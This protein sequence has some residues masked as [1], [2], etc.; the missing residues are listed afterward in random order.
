MTK[1]RRRSDQ[2]QMLVERT[3]GPSTALRSVEKHFQERSAEL[4]IPQLPGFPV[5][6]WCDQRTSCGFPQRK[7]HTW[8]SLVLRSRKSGVRSPGFPVEVGG[9]L[10]LHA[11]FLT[12][13]R[14]R[15]RVRRC[16]TG[17]PGRDDK[18]RVVACVRIRCWWR[19]LQI[20]PLRFAPVGMTKG[21]AALRSESD[22]GKEN[23]RF[24][25]FATLRSE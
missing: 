6:G 16:V 2:N 13:R 10:E 17:N 25:H 8:P 4:Q 23:C 24:L 3:A 21:R 1:R 9:F 7:P 5:D 12:E 19:E 15:C 20:P 18:V 11:P 14:T 22:A